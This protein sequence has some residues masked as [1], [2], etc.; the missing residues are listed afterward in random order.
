[1]L[2]AIS[3]DKNLN[4]AVL[5]DHGFT[6]GTLSRIE[7]VFELAKRYGETDWF[8]GEPLRGSGDILRALPRAPGGRSLRALLR[9]ASRQQAPQDSRRRC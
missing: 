4:A 9:R 8:P 6:T 7:A 5:A 1:L 2:G 3:S